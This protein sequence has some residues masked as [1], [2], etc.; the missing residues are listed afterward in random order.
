MQ[1]SI[2]KVTVPRLITL[3]TYVSLQLH[4]FSDASEE[5]FGAVFYARSEDSNGLVAVR[6]ITAK[7]RVSPAEKRSIPRL[8][9]CGAVV[10]ADLREKLNAALSIKFEKTF[11]WM[12]SA[13]AI[14][15]ISKSP[16]QL[17][18]FVA[19]RVSHIQEFTKDVKW[20]H[21]RGEENPADL[22]SRG[23]MPSEIVNNSF[24]F[25][26]PEFLK[27]KEEYWP[28]SIVTIDA[29]EPL[30]KNEFKKINAFPAQQALENDI[31]AMVESSSCLEK[32]FC[33]MFAQK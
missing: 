11:F 16:T 9:L 27:N 22:I 18:T 29:E 14:H 23:L 30:Y 2:N 32:A 15:W 13:I 1:A 25:N 6:L 17:Q 20:Q 7:S 21:V 19:N 5:G 26:G 24:W 3:S 33:S 28:T 12:D 8:E 10:M 4:G 31:I